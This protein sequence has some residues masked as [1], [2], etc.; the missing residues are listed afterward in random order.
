MLNNVIR[1]GGLQLRIT[2]G[3]GLTTEVRY[4]DF[5][6]VAKYA[7]PIGL[8]ANTYGL[9][10]DGEISATGEGSLL[11]DSN[12]FANHSAAMIYMN[13]VTAPQESIE[14]SNNQFVLGPSGQAI[15]LVGVDGA[16]ITGNSIQGGGDAAVRIFN[17]SRNV[18]LAR[19]TITG[20][21]YAAVETRNGGEALRIESN[22]FTGN[23]RALVLATDADAHLNRFAGNHADI[24]TCSGSIVNGRTTGLGATKGPRAAALSERTARHRSQCPHGS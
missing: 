11:V 22:T 18:L 15:D 14:I 4:N 5:I 3:D 20:N 2:V 1:E 13:S 8:P 17:D 10:I 21:A 16:R 7:W 12:R 6:G 24:Q 23:T 9:F 19:N